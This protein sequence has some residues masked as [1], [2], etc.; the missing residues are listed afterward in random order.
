MIVYVETSTGVTYN[1]TVVTTL[2]QAGG[3]TEAAS[4]LAN[5]D[6]AAGTDGW[7][8]QDGGDRPG[9][10]EVSARDGVLQI[11]RADTG[12]RTGMGGVI[13]LIDATP[14]RGKRVTLEA[15]VKVETDGP[16]DSGHL[17]VAASG[18]SASS[19]DGD[20]TWSRRSATIEVGEDTAQ[21]VLAL[22]L[23]GNGRAAF[24]NLD[25]AVE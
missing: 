4:E 12:F 8:V 1:P 10:Y 14:Y 22:R 9:A 16:F 23:R 3:P 5:L 18:T 24:R 21:L 6:F 25:V 11:A 19:E 13:Q 20:A 15:D 2:D 7:H 17:F